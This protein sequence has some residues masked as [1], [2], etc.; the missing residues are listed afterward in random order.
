[1]RTKRPLRISYELALMSRWSLLRRKRQH[2]VSRNM[3]EQW[4]VIQSIFPEVRERDDTLFADFLSQIV[5]EPD[6]FRAFFDAMCEG[7]FFQYYESHFIHTPA[8]DLI[9]EGRYNG[10]LLVAVSNFDGSA[11]KSWIKLDQFCFFLKLAAVFH[12]KHVDDTFEPWP[13]FPLLTKIEVQY[14][15]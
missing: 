5:F 7:R 14:K 13:A 3:K 12:A 8:E 10:S 4:A 1:M 11:S 15:M 9:D 6:Q 2:W